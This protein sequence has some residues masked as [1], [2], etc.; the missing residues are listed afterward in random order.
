MTDQQEHQQ[1]VDYF[2]T[3][4]SKIAHYW[5]KTNDRTLLRDYLDDVERKCRFCDQGSPQ[6]ALLHRLTP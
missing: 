6:V 1:R 2:N 3:R 5:F 4:Y